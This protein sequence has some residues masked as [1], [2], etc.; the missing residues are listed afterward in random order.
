M[1]FLLRH[2]AGDW[3]ELSTE[4]AHENCVAVAHE[5]DPDRQLRV[6]S[7]YRTKLGERIWVITEAD[8][9]TTTFLLPEEY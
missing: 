6:L 9:A 2:G 1:E 4:D 8:R 5:G 3:G 7:A